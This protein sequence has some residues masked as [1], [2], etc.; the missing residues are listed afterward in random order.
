MPEAPPRALAL[1]VY[2]FV[3]FA[4]FGVY[5]PFFP[6]WLEGRRFEGIHMSA[7]VALLPAM[8][9]VA[10][11]LFGWLSDRLRVRGSLLRWVCAGAALSFGAITWAARDGSPPYVVLLVAMAAFSLCRSPMALIADILA[12]ET[13]ERR[14]TYG[15]RRL[16][17]SVGFLVAAIGAGVW[18]DVTHPWALPAALAVTYACSFVTA[19]SLPRA[20][21]PLPVPVAGY[22]GVLLRR[23]SIVAFLVVALLSQAAHAGYDVCFSLHLRD[24][25]ASSALI[26]TAWAL[27]VIAEVCLLANA[28]RL[29]RRAA[30]VTLLGVGLAGAAVRWALL[31]V[32]ADTTLVLALQPLHALSFA[33]VWLAAIAFIKDSVQAERLG[34]LQGLFQGSLA[35]GSVVGMLAAGPLYE[36]ARGGPVFG[37]SA[38][39][40]LVGLCVWLGLRGRVMSGVPE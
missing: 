3:S 38:A 7:V 18:L 12:L 27:G 4:A 36:T 35:L 9:I 40:A 15:R 39:V 29:L 17:G 30:P 21:A 28:P 32:V 23:P 19:L 6:R 26:G 25:G 13:E 20:A 24:L 16:W 34:T 1:P 33:L 11:P 5:L 8:S 10:P 14:G 2:Y 37:A 31:A 22:A